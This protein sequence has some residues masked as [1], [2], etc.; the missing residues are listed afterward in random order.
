MAEETQY[1]VVTQP[2]I[3]PEARKAENTYIQSNV[4]IIRSWSY[5]GA[6]CN[7]W[8][9]VILSVKTLHAFVTENPC[10]G[11]QDSFIVDKTPR[12][13]VSASRSA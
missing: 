10:L 6:Q 9:E 12:D 4:L 13:V 7:T 3:K 11:N 2:D 8:L 1:I 5:R